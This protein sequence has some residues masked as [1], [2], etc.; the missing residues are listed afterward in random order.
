MIKK[1]LGLFL[2]LVSSLAFALPAAYVHEMSG[3][4]SALT[5]GKA[6]ALAVG[7]LLEE[8]DV[9]NV[10]KGILTLKFEDGQIVVLQ[11]KS[12]FAIEAYKYNKTKVAES[13]VV[14]SLLSGGMRYITG[15]IGG[16]RKE[17]IALKAGTATIGI[18][19]TDV[20][21][22]IAGAEYVVAMQ[23][24]SIEL[25]RRDAPSQIYSQ[26]AGS[27]PPPAVLNLVAGLTGTAL[28]PTNPV[29]VPQQAALV[30]AVESATNI[31]K[32]PNKTPE[33][34]AAATRDLQAKIITALQATKTAIEQALTGGAPPNVARVT[35]GTQGTPPGVPPQPKTQTETQQIINTINQNLPPAQQIITPPAV[36]LLEQQL[37]S[38]APTPGTLTTEQTAT[39][40]STATLLQS[41][42]TTCGGVGQSPC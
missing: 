3:S 16:T 2:V 11:E 19:G 38:A 6:R 35:Q 34:K 42:P 22:V 7:G 41:V 1:I 21:V 30:S 13:N 20:V 27:S 24:G 9:I 33:E 40:E 29:G 36:Q 17:A 32:D 37:L 25:T 28:P 15:V 26:G 18:R 23:S 5:K 12:R 31:I 4:G 10:E 39:L 8:G 14:L